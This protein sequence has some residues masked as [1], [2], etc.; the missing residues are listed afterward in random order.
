MKI[1]FNG[2]F[3][4]L[5]ASSALAACNGASN[6]KRQ[7][8]IDS[9][10][11]RYIGRY[12]KTT[13]EN[14]D[15]MLFSNSCSGFEI[16]VDVDN[17]SNKLTYKLYGEN[18]SQYN[19]QYFNVYIDDVFVKKYSISNETKEFVIFENIEVGKHTIRLNKLNET[20]FSKMALVSI[21]SEGL[22][23]YKTESKEK[24]IE[25]YG[26]SIT[27][28][29]GNLNKD[30]K[31]EELLTYTDGMQAYTQ[32]CAD[33]LG[34]ESSVIGYSG[35]G[36]A[37][38]PNNQEKYLPD[39]YDTV[40]GNI[41]WNFSNYTPDVV[42]INIGTNDTATYLGLHGDDKTK[43]YEDF[44]VAYK[45]LVLSLK[46]KYPKVKIVA[47]A[48]MMIPLASDFKTAIESVINY[49][50]DNYE[51]F[52]YYIEFEPNAEGGVGHPSKDA[53]KLFGQQLAEFIKTI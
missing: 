39:V 41:K 17:S 10:E 2:I 49:V 3:V 9:E 5:L 35:I 16:G 4:L 32:I 29:F 33:E 43:A 18:V 50:H 25:F 51:E 30:M 8:S 6:E 12:A 20:Q 27:C 26:D 23:F 13:K 42:V 22:S 47:A 28:G 24:K 14:I 21:D 46:N 48:D 19:E 37:M 7:V 52:M 44:F 53:H 1:N 15:M 38:S 45:E 36:L 31:D 11:V 40:D 34:Y